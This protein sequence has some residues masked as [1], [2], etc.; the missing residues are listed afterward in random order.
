MLYRLL[1][2]VV[3]VAHLAFIVFAL[4]GGLLA[5]RFPWTALVH[6]PAAG[7]GAFVELTGRICPLTP[8]ENA[9][10]ARAGDAGYAEDFIEHYLLP[11]LY[12]SALTRDVQ[13]W[14]AGGVIAFNVLIYIYVV[15]RRSTRG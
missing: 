8:L 10:R 1:A 4:F 11:A 14:L 7:W 2:D 6:L 3:L 9:F 13:L 12:P 5:I 15:H